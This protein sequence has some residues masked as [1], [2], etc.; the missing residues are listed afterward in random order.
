M[1]GEVKKPGEYTLEP[2]SDFVD[3]LVQAGGFTDRA[4]LDDIELIRRV[5]GIKRVYDF[6]WNDFQRAPAP[7]QGDVVFVHADNVSK[8]ERHITLFA[9]IIAALASIVT[10]AI[11]VVAYNNNRP[12]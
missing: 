4:D 2:G 10:S 6:S 1:M 9:T 5:G 12:I 3:T 8:R 7:Q 11:L